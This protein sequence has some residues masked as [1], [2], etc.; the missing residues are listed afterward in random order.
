LMLVG[1]C[2]AGLAHGMDSNFEKRIAADLHGVVEISNVAGSIEVQAWDNPEVEVKADVGAGVDRIDTTSEHGRVTIKVIVPNHSFRSISTTLHVRVPRDSELDISGVSAEVST[3]DVEGALQLK[4]VSGGVRAD[5][6]QKN[7]EVKTIS[8]D[9]VLRGHGKE[10]GAAGIHV[11]TISGGI[12]IERAGGDVEA[13]TVSG[14]LSVRLDH[15]AHNVRFRTTSGSVGFEG[16]LTK[17]AYLDGESI[18]G[19]LTVRAAPEGS[20]EYEVSAFS[21]DIKSCMGGEAERVS[22]YGPGR[23]LNGT[24]GAPGTE[25]A[26]I[27]LKTLSGNVELCDKS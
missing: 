27:R 3:S 20:L 13:T 14:D 17:G 4:T 1:A 5:V 8:G 7:T 10:A 25:E 16:R 21:G 22:K 6:F 24:R 2:T 15:P 18:S 11:S 23:R 19:D 26:K 12:R 9:V